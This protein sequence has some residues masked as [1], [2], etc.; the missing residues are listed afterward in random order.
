MTG[1]GAYG[2][3]EG[4]ARILDADF[5]SRHIVV[6]ETRAAVP[7]EDILARIESKLDALAAK[8]EQAK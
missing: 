1:H 3:I 4:K 2:W 5:S 6:A 7:I 8:L